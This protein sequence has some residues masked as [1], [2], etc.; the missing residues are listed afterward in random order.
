MIPAA[1]TLASRQHHA[2]LMT[3]TAIGGRLGG[4]DMGTD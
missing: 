3:V 1:T 4:S 2:N